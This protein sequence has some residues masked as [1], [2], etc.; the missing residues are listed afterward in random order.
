MQ[1]AGNADA[2]SDK[3]PSLF[4]SDCIAQSSVSILIGVIL[5]SG[6]GAPKPVIFDKF[7]D[8]SYRS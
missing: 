3:I 6:H 5:P 7:L 1:P 4:W 8:E 2:L